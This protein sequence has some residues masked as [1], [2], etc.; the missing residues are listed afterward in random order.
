MGKVGKSGPQAPIPAETPVADKR[1]GP[2]GVEHLGDPLAALRQLS[3]D[4]IA[5][6]LDGE[7][8]RTISLVLDALVTTHAGEVLKRLPLE[9]RREVSIRLGQGLEGNKVLLQQIARALVQ[10]TRGNENLGSKSSALRASK[11]AEMLRALDRV[12]RLDLLACARW[13][14]PIRKRPHE[15]DPVS[16]GLKT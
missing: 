10:K 2:S 5:A 4:Q 13:Q 15:L 8:T 12:D 9:V 14:P 11:I 3:A 7:H 6:A 1:I 16:I